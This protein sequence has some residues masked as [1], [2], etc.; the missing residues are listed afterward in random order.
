MAS[1]DRSLTRRTLIH[2]AVFAGGSVALLA[3]LSGLLLWVSGRVVPAVV[4]VREDASAGVSKR[5]GP[6]RAPGIEPQR[7]GSASEAVEESSVEPAEPHPEEERWA[8][9]CDALDRAARQAPAEDRLIYQAAQRA[10]RGVLGDAK[11]GE[12]IRAMLKEENLPP[13][14][15]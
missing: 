15:R 1:T 12:A 3:L 7:E 9:C 8:R 11:G 10:C 6:R 4:E 14:C 5:A 13:E 2:I